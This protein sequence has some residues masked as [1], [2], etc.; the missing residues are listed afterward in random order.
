[1]V[2]LASR[3]D[4]PYALAVEEIVVLL[5]VLLVPCALL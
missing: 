3:M 5:L 2:G 4:E 1:M